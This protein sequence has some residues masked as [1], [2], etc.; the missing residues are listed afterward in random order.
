MKTCQVILPTTYLFQAF[1]LDKTD[2]IFPAL[3]EVLAEIVITLGHDYDNVDKDKLAFEYS[4][5]LIEMV[6]ELNPE[7]NTAEIRVLKGLRE[8]YQ[9][10]FLLWFNEVK[11][12][13][14]T[15]FSEI[16]K[17]VT[18]EGEHLW[19]GGDLVITIDITHWLWWEDTV[20]QVKRGSF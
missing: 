16:P 18:K 10:L 12:M 3:K 9:L 14:I 5:L 1:K 15:H 6:A 2:A 8:T 19:F 7:F 4:N 11:R 20:C 17:V 13:Y